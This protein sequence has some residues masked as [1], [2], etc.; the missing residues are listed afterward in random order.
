MT[1]HL[2]EQA[3]FVTEP[4]VMLISERFLVYASSEIN[5]ALQETSNW[6]GDRFSKLSILFVFLLIIHYHHGFEIKIKKSMQSSTNYTRYN[7]PALLCC[8]SFN[9]GIFP[10]SSWYSQYVKE[11]SK[12]FF[13][14]LFSYI[15]TKT[16][17]HI[18][19]FDHMLYISDS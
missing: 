8:R 9:G 4:A 19:H 1:L 11:F 5:G 6:L 14:Y 2:F 10:C 15:A 12:F 17:H 13:I 18:W 3:S 16:S 7:Y